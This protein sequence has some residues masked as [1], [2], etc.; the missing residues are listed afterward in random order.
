MMG[1]NAK[2]SKI[3]GKR[4]DG[5]PTPTQKA[6][7]KPWCQKIHNPDNGLTIKQS[8]SANEEE[9]P[10]MTPFSFKAPK[11]S[12][13]LEDITYDVNVMSLLT[14]SRTS[15]TKDLDE[16]RGHVTTR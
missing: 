2:T 11:R 14:P 3:I 8:K 12:S 16:T 15:I 9:N 1:G 10:Q 4:R 13:N 6:T 5:F 7:W